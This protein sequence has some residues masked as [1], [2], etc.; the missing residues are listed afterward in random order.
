MCTIEAAII[1]NVIPQA[2]RVVYYTSNIKE[3]K[4]PIRIMKA[5]TS[6]G[7]RGLLENR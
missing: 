2:L 3:P 1:T 4:N 5:S 7:G 6:D